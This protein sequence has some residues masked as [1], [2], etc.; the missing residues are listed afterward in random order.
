MVWGRATRFRRPR[1]QKSLHLTHSLPLLL[2]NM[3]R[4]LHSQVYLT[5]MWRRSSQFA[6]KKGLHVDIRTHKVCWRV[7]TMAL[8]FFF[9]FSFW[10]CVH[11]LIRN[12]S[13][14]DNSAISQTLQVS[15]FRYLPRSAEEIFRFNGLSSLLIEK[16][17]NFKYRGTRNL[18]FFY[19]KLSVYICFKSWKSIV[20]SVIVHGKSKRARNKA[21]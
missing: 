13:H 20:I 8:N 16:N 1:G 18:L 17:N 6:T 9:G 3:P 11:F 2:F 19:C 5:I 15:N 14:A 4:L 10:N 7:R 12:L 21:K